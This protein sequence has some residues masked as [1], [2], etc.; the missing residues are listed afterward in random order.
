MRPS[1]TLIRQS[2]FGGEDLL[3]MVDG[4]RTDGRRRTPEHWFTISSSCEP[5]G[6][7]E[8]KPGCTT[9]EDGRRLEILDL[10]SWGI[11]PFI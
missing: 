6:S 9:T 1:L 3:K 4:R 10:G 5:D 2:S 11:I 7:A 8:L